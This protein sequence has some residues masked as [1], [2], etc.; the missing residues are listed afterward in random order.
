[1]K[2]AHEL[3]ALV[4]LSLT[5]VVGLAT[6]VQQN[7]NKPASNQRS[8][9]QSTSPKES[10]IARGKYLVEEVAQCPECHTP[11]DSQGNLDRL[12][13]LQGAPIWIVPTNKRIPWAQNAPA[14][15]GFPYTDQQGLDVLERGLGTNGLPIEKPMHI[16]HLRHEDAVAIITYLRSL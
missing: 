16:Y 7:P 15:K 13:W 8:I 1:M 5:A 12:H 6:A 4:I 10:Q 2:R 3:A 14:L 11:R 9:T